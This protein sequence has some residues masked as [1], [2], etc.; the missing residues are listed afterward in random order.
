MSARVGLAF[1]AGESPEPFV[2]ILESLRDAGVTVTV[3][4]DGLWAE[5]HPDLVR[6]TLVDGHELG[7]HGYGH[8][9]WRDLTDD[10]IREDLRRVE[11]IVEDIAAGARLAPW[12]L[13]PLLG[14]NE[15]VAG[16]LAGAGYRAINRYPIDGNSYAD[17]SADRI[18]ARALDQ[19]A[20]NEV[21][22]IHTGRW[23][24]AEA[25]PG[26]VADLGARGL[27]VSRISELEGVPDYPAVNPPTH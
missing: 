9:D 22:T 27:V 4:L 2:A 12:A 14:F 26:I 15:R 20:P 3:F 16:V 8:P 1:E 18:R 6:A 21:V 17:A 7:N 5:Q 23:N 13:P 24:S 11:S 19:A 10:E 25:I